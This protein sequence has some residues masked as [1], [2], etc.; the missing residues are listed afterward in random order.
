M[1]SVH[2]P[3][4]FRDFL[5]DEARRR[6]KLMNLITSVYQSF[7][8]LPLE[9]PVLENLDIL[10]GGGGG[11]ENE[12][13]IFKILKRGAKLEEALQSRQESEIAE[14]GLRFDMTLPLSR[15]VALH[16]NEIRFPWKVFH[17]GPVWRAERA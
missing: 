5:N 6:L 10:M 15:A 11:E 16:R 12:K 1:I 9:T 7:G 2:P 3:S 8:F 13:L 14:F 4:G 17:M